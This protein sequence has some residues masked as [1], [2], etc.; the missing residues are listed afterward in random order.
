ME[1]RSTASISQP[2]SA[3]AKAHHNHGLINPVSRPS[4]GLIL[5]LGLQALGSGSSRLLQTFSSSPVENSLLHCVLPH[6]R[7]A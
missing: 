2:S 1:P 3:S 7:P 5:L 6:H 4:T